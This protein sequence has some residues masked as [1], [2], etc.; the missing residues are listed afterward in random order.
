MGRQG[1]Q[2]KIKGDEGGEGNKQLTIFNFPFSYYQLRSRGLINSLNP[3][4]NNDK[5]TTIK[6]MAKP[7]KR[8]VHQIPVGIAL[9]AILKSRPH[10]GICSGSP[11]P[12]N[13]KAPKMRIASAALR[14]KSTGTL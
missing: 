10:S 2:G 7:G 8:A 1:K 6:V 3:S 5:P 13:P 4:P 12:K 14:V 11:S 9:R